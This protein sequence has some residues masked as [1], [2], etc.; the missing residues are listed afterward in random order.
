MNRSQWEWSL[1]RQTWVTLFVWFLLAF[2]I[3][4][5]WVGP[6]PA[7][8]I[9]S[10]PAVVVFFLAWRLLMRGL[11]PVHQWALFGVT[12][13]WLVLVI[14]AWDG[15][16]RFVPQSLFAPVLVVLVLFPPLLGA[17]VVSLAR[18]SETS[19]SAA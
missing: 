12:F 5:G 2:L 6:G 1:T 17:L 16:D 8:L 3:S 4:F 11:R 13:L 14:A 10:A 19:S 18:Q 7:F 15:G 9:W